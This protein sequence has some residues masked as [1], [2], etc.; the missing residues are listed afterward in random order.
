[1]KK[2]SLF[3]VVLAML[4]SP[5]FASSSVSGANVKDYAVAAAPDNWG[6]NPRSNE[7]AMDNSDF[8]LLRSLLKEASFDSERIKMIRVA[9]IG[10][11]FSS[12][13]CAE[14]L[15]IFSFDSKKLDALKYLAPYV[16]DRNKRAREVILKEFSFKS[17]KEKAE[18]LLFERKAR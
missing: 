7:K 13:Q 10:N 16:L 15:S 3:V 6:R 18:A 9:C 8:K 1:M 17:N 5:L 11:R 4:Q 2:L 14:I 12:K